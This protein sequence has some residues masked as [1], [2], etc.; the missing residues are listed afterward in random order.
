MNRIEFSLIA[1]FYEPCSQN[2]H[3][4]GSSN[5]SKSLIWFANFL[6]L[7]NIQFEHDK[8]IRIINENLENLIIFMQNFY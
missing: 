5:F 3:S 6:N 2:G 4:P 8:I 7:N 1:V